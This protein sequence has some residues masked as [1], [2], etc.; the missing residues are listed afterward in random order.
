M[1]TATETAPAP[2][3]DL[4]ALPPLVRWRRALQALGRV[5]ANPEETDQV[6]VFSS[7]VNAASMTD[8]MEGFFASPEGARLY[9]EHRTIDSKTIDLD[10]LL[11]LPS[12]TLGHAYATFLRSRGLTPEVFDKPPEGITD[13]RASYLIQRM[14]QTHDL[15]HVV[16]GCE[17][18]PAGE[19]ALQAFLYAQTRA[20]GSAILA[21]MGTLRTARERP[22][23]ARPLV[24]DVM[25]AYRKGK[26]AE[27]LVV[28]PWE[29]HWATSLVEVRALLGLPTTPA[30]RAVPLAA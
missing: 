26:R 9:A 13:P 23:I 2:A 3:L 8:R 25:A 21:T 30:P 14:R 17:T 7:Y 19:V 24:R 16:T 6:L 28:F 12:D 1:M 18:D 10:T 20:P 27:K 22:G 5:L 15:W 4:A 11:A 29:Q